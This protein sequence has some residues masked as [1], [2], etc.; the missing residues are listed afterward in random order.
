MCNLVLSDPN[1][2]GVIVSLDGTSRG[3]KARKLALRGYKIK[4]PSHDQ[5][6]WFLKYADLPDYPDL[7]QPYL[8]MKKGFDPPKTGSS[9]RPKKVYVPNPFTTVTVLV[10]KELGHVTNV[11]Q[12]F[13]EGI[14]QK[15]D[16][17]LDDGLRKMI[18][19]ALKKI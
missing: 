17:T 3:F 6:K 12:S 5:E 7:I 11:D 14:A 4:Y 18:D 9:Y 19:A 8:D 10:K 15:M 13:Y 2:E 16:R 1:E